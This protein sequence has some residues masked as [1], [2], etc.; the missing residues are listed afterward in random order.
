MAAAPPT[1]H[2]ALPVTCAIAALVLWLAPAVEDAV[3]AAAF[4]APLPDSPAAAVAD[5]VPVV[6]AV[7]RPAVGEVCA[8]ADPEAISV[9]VMVTV[10]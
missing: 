2:L 1:A 5:A 10:R 6:V 9:P 8:E 4:C 7:A 3:F